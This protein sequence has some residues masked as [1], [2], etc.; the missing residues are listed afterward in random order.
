VGA[1][2][3]YSLQWVNW[4]MEWYCLLPLQS[5]KKFSIAENGTLS[6]RLELLTSPII[7]LHI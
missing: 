7:V 5:I 3:R 4:E 1:S 6:S 2:R